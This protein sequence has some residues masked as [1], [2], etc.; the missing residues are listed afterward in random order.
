ETRLYKDVFENYNKYNRPVLKESQAV[1]VEFD[2]QLIR[3]IDVSAK[4]QFIKTY[5]WINQ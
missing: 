1:L 3:I 2:Y 5:A 4:D